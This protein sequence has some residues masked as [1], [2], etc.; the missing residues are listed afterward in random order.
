MLRSPSAALV[1]LLSLALVASTVACSVETTSAG[2][3]LEDDPPATAPAPGVESTT[4][5]PG[6]ELEEKE[7]EPE[8]KEEESVDKTVR[9]ELTIDGASI[10]PDVVK[11]EV[12]PAKNGKP[13]RLV[14]DA[15]H[16]QVQNGPFTSTATFTLSVDLTEKGKDAC[17]S[18][19]SIS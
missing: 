14:V 18:V 1:S 10:V 12:E 11:V 3:G 15:S 4:P 2:G 19:V 8:E 16:E 7:G 6:D 13:A 5:R 9:F 17:S